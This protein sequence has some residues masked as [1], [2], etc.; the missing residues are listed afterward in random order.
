MTKEEKLEKLFD[1]ASEAH[2][3]SSWKDVAVLGAEYKFGSADLVEYVNSREPYVED[4]T[5]WVLRAELFETAVYIL[6]VTHSHEK[7]EF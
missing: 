1:T 4:N 6:G 5:D 2:D 3:E 7:G